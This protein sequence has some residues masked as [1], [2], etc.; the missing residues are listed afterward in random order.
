MLHYI[1]YYNKKSMKKQIF[2]I[3]NW[4]MY[5]N[6]QVVESFFEEFAY[7]NEAVQ[8]IIAPSVIHIPLA[9]AKKTENMAIASQN[10]AAEELGAFTGEVAAEQLVEQGVELAIIG[11]SERRSLY[12]ETD[13]IIAKKLKLAQKYNITPILC[14]GETSAEKETGQSVTVVL[15]QIAAALNGG[16]VGEKMIIAYEPVWAIGSGKTPMTVDIKAIVDSVRN[17][18][19]AETRIVYGGSVSADN[20]HAIISEAGCDGALIGK[21]STTAESLTAICQVVAH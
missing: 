9:V 13:E 10:I 6:E 14:V 16:V 15:Q 5:Q 8:V 11:H 12:G 4:K 1:H 20:V 3:A 17:A 18:H 21:A 19:G 7:N 2:I